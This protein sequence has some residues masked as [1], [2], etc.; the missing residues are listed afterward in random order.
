MFSAGPFSSVGFVMATLIDFRR[1]SAR[2]TVV[3]A[4]NNINTSIQ[5]AVS[6]FV[7]MFLGALTRLSQFRQ[8]FPRDGA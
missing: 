7:S 2:T 1:G 8:F 5:I 6:F 3:V 4:M